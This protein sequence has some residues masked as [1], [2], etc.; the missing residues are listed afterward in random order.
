[1]TMFAI[2]LVL[3]QVSLAVFFWVFRKLALQKHEALMLQKRHNEQLI[4]RLMEMAPGKS[5][6][7]DEATR[8]VQQLRDEMQALAVRHQHEVRWWFRPIDEEV[9]KQARA[10]ARGPAC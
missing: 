4:K 3:T 2:G 8:F 9:R 7:A 5:V 1:M 10:D 6:T